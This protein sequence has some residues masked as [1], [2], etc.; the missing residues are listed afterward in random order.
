MFNLEQEINNWCA[1]VHEFGLDKAE[2]IEELKDH[3][4]CEVERLMKGEDLTEEQAFYI[5]IEYT[6]NADDLKN[7]YSKNDTVFSM[8]TD[9]AKGKILKPMNTKKAA[10]L[11]IVTALVF[12]SLM[13]I[14]DYFVDRSQYAIHS[15]TINNWMIALYMIPLFYLSTLEQ[16]C[17]WCGFATIKQKVSN[18]FHKG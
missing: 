6:G 3:L 1:S 12:A 11:Q 16:P 18:L 17:G 2:R 13:I 9:I 14:I 5:A 8:L 15:Q 10:V 7:E 4:L